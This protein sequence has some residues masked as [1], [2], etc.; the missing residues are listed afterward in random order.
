MTYEG[1]GFESTTIKKLQYN[2]PSLKI[3]A[4]Q[5]API[6]NSQE[7]FFQGLK[8]FTGNTM[9]LTSG[10][11]PRQIVVARFPNIEQ[12]VM[13]LG[14]EKYLLDKNRDLCLQSHSNP[15]ALLAPE[16]SLGAVK[17]LLQCSRDIS[18][19]FRFY[20]VIRLHPRLH[21]RNLDPELRRDLEK[22]EIST[23]QSL[24]TELSCSK[25][26][27]YRSSAVGIQA[28]QF[29]VIPIYVSRFPNTLLDP[30]YLVSELSDSYNFQASILQ[31]LEKEVFELENKDLL[32]NIFNIGIQYF[33]EID[34]GV[35]NLIRN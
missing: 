29:H 16:A 5:H 11:I 7:S 10:K 22:I 8:L 18:E 34:Y 1:H 23:T 12:N 19:K 4:Y 33:S 2:F 32:Q 27:F 24:T 25:V 30:F 3:F 14:S 17:E 13:V 26:C 35:L 31:N 21:F 9:L 6:V 15:K 28:M 20:D